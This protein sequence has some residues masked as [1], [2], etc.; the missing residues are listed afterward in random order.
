M[1]SLHHS[2]LYQE[3]YSY[4]PILKKKKLFCEILHITTFAGDLVFSP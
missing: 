2:D 4:V 1:K 3:N